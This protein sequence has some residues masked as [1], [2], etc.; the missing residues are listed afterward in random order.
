MLRLRNDIFRSVRKSCELFAQK[1]FKSDS[2]K[3]LTYC[4]AEV[5]RIINRTPRFW[6]NQNGTLYC[7]CFDCC[8]SRTSLLNTIRSDMEFVM[9]TMR[10]NG[11][12]NGI[13]DFARRLK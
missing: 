6:T 2:M 10:E 5:E 7:I 8:N 11:I 4:L 9:I 12:S 13:A 3:R 1:Y